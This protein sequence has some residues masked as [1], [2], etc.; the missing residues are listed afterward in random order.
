MESHAE[1]LRVASLDADLAAAV[2]R[3]W[4]AAAITD[5]ERAM[6]EYV[7]KLTRAPRSIWKDDV[8]RLRAAGFDDTGIL[9]INLIASFFGYVNRVADGLGVG[10]G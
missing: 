5:A 8:D 1:F 10:R 7:E 4:R 3:D 2:R 9:Q 6:L